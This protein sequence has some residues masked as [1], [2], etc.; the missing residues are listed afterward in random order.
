MTQLYPLN[1]L[2]KMPSV[3]DG[4][5]PVQLVFT[6]EYAGKTTKSIFEKYPGANEDGSFPH[7]VRFIFTPQRDITPWEKCMC[8]EVELDAA[9][10]SDFDVSQA[11]EQR[12]ISRHYSRAVL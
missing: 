12:G 5:Q 8:D 2:T 4:P 7:F 1:I 10:Q 11:L 3:N 6:T 9:L